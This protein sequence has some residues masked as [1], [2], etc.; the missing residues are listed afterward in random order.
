MDRKPPA[1]RATPES[2]GVYVHIPFCRSKCD[3]CGFVSVPLDASRAERYL[4]AIVQEIATFTE[5]EVNERR[6]DTIYF[7]GGT[8]SLMPVAHIAAIMEACRARFSLTRNCEISM[9]ANPGTLAEEK[10]KGYQ[11]LGVNRVSLGAQSFSDPELAALGRVHTVSQ[12]VESAAV[13]KAYGLTNLSLDLMLGI[14]GQNEGQ[15]MDSLE[16]AVALEPAHLSVYMLELDPKVP[17]YGSLQRGE[18]SVPD[19]DLVADWYLRAIDFLASRGYRQYEI[20][21]FA[22]PGCECRHNLK[23]WRREP[24]LAF[25]AAAHSFD[26]ISRYANMASLDGYLRSVEEET[27]AVEWREEVEPFRELEEV[28]FLG[29]RLNCGLDWR[30][31]RRKYGRD[32]LSAFEP[33]IKEMARAGLLE[34]FGST[35][36]LTRRGML[37]SNEVFQNFVGRRP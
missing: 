25:G 3:Y 23:Y 27:S 4:D 7:G 21:N 2:T 6:V 33:S 18:R 1:G 34:W 35:I 31:L 29:L 8:P 5:S 12:I 13:L 22:R 37:L 9:E 11:I 20:S 30:D 24:V 17:L 15:W 28:L 10:V 14:P 19:D 26:G 32:R 16:S 36:R